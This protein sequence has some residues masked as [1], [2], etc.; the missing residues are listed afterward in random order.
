M[1]GDAH[2]PDPPCCVLPRAAPTRPTPSCV[3]PRPARPAPYC[4]CCSTP[5]CVHPERVLS[6]HYYLPAHLV[7]LVDVIPGEKT[8]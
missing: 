1:R 6:A 7:P 5:S 4:F 2:C 3:L 8:S